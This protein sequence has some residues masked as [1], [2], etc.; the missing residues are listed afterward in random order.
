MI[1]RTAALSVALILSTAANAGTVQCK[2]AAGKVT[3]TNLPCEGQTIKPESLEASAYNSPYGEWLGQVQFKESMSGQTSGLAQ[4]VA[5]MTL[6]IEAAGR[7]TGASNETGCRALGIAQPSSVV[8]LLSLDVS[9]TGCQQSVFNQRYTGTLGV[10]PHDKYA[11]VYVI[12]TPTLL[13]K[14]AAVY[15]ITGTM[16]R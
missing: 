13:S 5:A 11:A 10:Y 15:T 2:D 14:K 7:L 6:K 3:Y 9:V 8:T 12:S 1:L 4:A 16:R